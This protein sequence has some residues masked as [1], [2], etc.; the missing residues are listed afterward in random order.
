[1]PVLD[2][3]WMVNMFFI[4]IKKSI[5]LMNEQLNRSAGKKMFWKST[6]E[7]KQMKLKAD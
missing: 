5:A 4:R 3:G 7:R 1:M 6:N 2:G